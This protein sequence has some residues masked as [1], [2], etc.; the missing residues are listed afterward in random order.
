LGDK[1]IDLK[2]AIPKKFSEYLMYKGYI[3][4]NG[5]S[6]TIGK[7]ASNHFMLHLIPETLAATNLDIAENGDVLNIEIDQNTISIV[8]TVKRVLKNSS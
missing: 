7:V 5:C 2:V 8:E 6:L 4:V 1:T 3:G